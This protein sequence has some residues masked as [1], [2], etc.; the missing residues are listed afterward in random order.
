MNDVL[1]TIQTGK[2]ALAELYL[3]TNSCTTL[4]FDVKTMQGRVSD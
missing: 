2:V 1:E 4:A 3:F